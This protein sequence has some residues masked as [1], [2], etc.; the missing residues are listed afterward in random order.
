MEIHSNFY[1]EAS[2]ESFSAFHIK[3]T[4]GFPLNSSG[5]LL[6]GDA[7]FNTIKTSILFVESRVREDLREILM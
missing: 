7:Q 6:P 4:F 3:H 1:S 2:F 5:F